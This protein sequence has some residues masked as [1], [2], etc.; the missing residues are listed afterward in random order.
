MAEVT[1][2]DITGKLMAG[3]FEHSGDVAQTLSDPVV[4]TPITVT[5]DQIHP[6][7]LNPRVTRNPRYDEIKASIRER[8][9]DAPPQ[10]T[11]RPGERHYI[12]RNGGNTRLAILRELWSE[13]KDQ[14]FFRFSCLF[15]PWPERGEIVALTGHLAE[16]ELHGGLSFIERSLGVE[17]VREL[18][19]QESGKELSQSELARQLYADGYPVPQPHISRM[20]DAVRYLLPA[21]PTV[22]YGGLGRP[23]VERLTALRRA[24][25]RIWDAHSAGKRLNA[26]FPTLFNDV[27]M[28]F[29][30]DVDSFLVKRVQDEL[31][32]QM[33]DMLEAD[34]DTLTL[35]VAETENKQRVWSPLPHTHNA[36]T[37]PAAQSVPHTTALTEQPQ[38]SAREP[39]QK[40]EA[41]VSSQVPTTRVP[42]A[43]DNSQPFANSQ[44][45]R[46]RRRN[47]VAAQST[48]SSESERR[49][50]AAQTNMLP[51]SPAAADALYPSADLWRI[52]PSLD[53]PEHLR[54]RV[55]QVAREIACEAGQADHIEALD[56]GIGFMVTEVPSAQANALPFVARAVLALLNALSAG[57]PP[58]AEVPPDNLNLALGPLLQGRM[59]ASTKLPSR[60]SD[61]SLINLFRLVSLTRRL[62]EL[63]AG[64]EANADASVRSHRKGGHDVG[65]KSP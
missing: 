8:G 22:L 3:R 4:D 17:K 26:D 18:Y 12:I 21:I 28:Q 30:G 46:P 20:Q 58:N 14:Q 11:R 9:L 23:Q 48:D 52:E 24:G 34:Y 5:L 1:P 15:R 38:P 45:E 57:Y 50:G 39:E 7:D 37:E 54:M 61:Q 47:A 60:L 55:A 10:I 56:D 6:Y 42:E 49:A 31:I 32:G 35:E 65:S 27:L 44:D 64:L 40:T 63:E 59:D 43:A 36:Q 29:D 2:K 62:L 19:E 25:A 53:A 13:T 33:A 51:K 41:T 16:N